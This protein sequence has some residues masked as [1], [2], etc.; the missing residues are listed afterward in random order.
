MPNRDPAA[1]VDAAQEVQVATQQAQTEAQTEAQSPPAQEQ[2]QEPQNALPGSEATKLRREAAGYRVRAR[3]AETERDGL[4]VRLDRH[5][6]AQVEQMAAEHL[7]APGDL[8]L[9][10]EMTDLRDD[11]GEVDPAKVTAAIDRA[12]EQRPHWRR[13]GRVDFDA[14]VRS[15]P[16]LP[17]PGFGQTLKDALRGGS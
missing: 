16:Q 6:R 3:E 1:T 13:T 9:T 2:A 8:F 15:A 11:A 7:A 4:R 14:G 12:V 17:K 10:V 5:D